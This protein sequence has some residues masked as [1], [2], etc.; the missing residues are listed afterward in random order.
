MFVPIGTYNIESVSTCIYFL[1]K[2]VT[3]FVFAIRSG[4]HLNL[5]TRRIRRNKLI[6]Q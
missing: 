3:L 1:L 4:K 5:Q 2:F 6:Y